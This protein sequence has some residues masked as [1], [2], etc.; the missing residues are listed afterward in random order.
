MVSI[1]I[2]KF[3]IAETYEKELLVG[4]IDK[5]LNIG[6]SLKKACDYLSEKKELGKKE[7]YNLYL[8]RQFKKHDDQESNE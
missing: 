3:I 6:A 5:L 8:S 2:P 4:E 1:D 7:L